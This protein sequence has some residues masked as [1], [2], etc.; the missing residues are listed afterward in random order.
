[1]TYTINSGRKKSKAPSLPQQSLKEMTDE[2]RSGKVIVSD[3]DDPS[4]GWAIYFGGGQVHYAHS[5]QGQGFRLNYLLQKYFPQLEILRCD[6]I[7]AEHLDSDYRWICDHWQ[8]NH[9][10]LNV[11]RQVLTTLTTEA[12]IHVLAMPQAKIELS[13][14]IGLDPLL[15]SVPF[16]QLILPVRE[17]INHWVVLQ[18][19]VKSPFNRFQMTNPFDFNE[20]GT[21]NLPFALET[22]KDGIENGHCLYQLAQATEL[23]IEDL[24]SFLATP[25]GNQNLFLEPFQY[26]EECH[27]PAIACVDDSQTIQHFVKLAL[28][29]SGYDVISLLDPTE[30]LKV[31]L[32]RQPQLILMDI[33]MPKMDGYE[34]CKM[35]RQV[36]ILRKTPV[37]MLTGREGL[38]DRVR[39]KMLGTSAYLTKPFNPT[40]MLALVQKLTRDPS[41]VS[42]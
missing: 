22:L 38:I 6:A 13:S 15:L 3:P 9:I 37:V 24:G 34:L 32:D 27:Q 17:S 29:P 41:L 20:A 8:A 26:I 12:L 42:V 5:T 10:P 21:D 14:S 39:A 30:A 11:V 36:E 16:R 23:S 28:E 1:M 4:I 31:L 35:V 19:A 2:Q 33:E 18:S 25:I 40:E 7:E